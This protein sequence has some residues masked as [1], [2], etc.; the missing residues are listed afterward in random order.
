MKNVYDSAN[1]VVKQVTPDGGVVEFCYD[2]EGMCT[3]ERDQNG[4]M[5]SYESDD[6]FRNIRTIYGDGEEC[7]GYNDSNQMIFYADR[8]GNQTRYSYDTRGNLTGIKDALGN[9]MGFTYDNGGRITSVMSDGKVLGKNGYDGK[10][11][12]VETS[13]ALGRNRKMVYGKNGLPEQIIMPDGS[14]IRLEYDERGNIQS[15]NDPYG[16]ETIYVYDGLNRVTESTDAE[17]NTTSYRYNELNRLISVVNSEGNSRC[18]NYNESGMP[19][20][21]EDFDGSTLSVT[22]NAMGKP[23]RLIDKEGRETVRSYNKSGDISREVSPSGA[24]MDFSYDRNDRLV[25]VELR[26]EDGQQTADMVITYGYDP[27]GNLINVGMGDGSHIFSQTTYS[28]DVLNRMVGKVDS[29][30]GKTVYSYDRLGRISSVTDPSGNQRTFGYNA[31]GELTEETDVRGNTIRYEYNEMGRVTAVTDGAGRTVRNFYVRG[32]RLDKSVYP[33]GSQ[34]D[35]T[36]DKLGRIKSKTDGQGNQ[37]AYEYDRMGRVISV[38]GSEGQNKKYAYDAVGNVISMTD[39]NGNT[40]FYE[41]TLSGMLKTVTDVLGNKTEYIYDSGDRLICVSRKGEAEKESREVFYDRNSFGQVECIRDALG[42]E[43][44][45]AYDA[46]GRVILKTDRDGYQTAYG[47]EADGK[48]KSILYGDGTGVEME[49]TALRQLSLIKDWMG[50]TRV[51][52]DAVG[53]PLNITDY[54]G[55]TVAYEWG[56]MG[57]RKSVNY[58][59]GAKVSYG[60][61]SL[62]RLER[63]EVKGAGRSGIPE[64]ILYRYDTAGRLAEKKLPDGMRTMWRYDGNGQLSELIHEDRNGLLDCYRYEYDLTGNKTAVIKERKG[65]AE[66]SGRYEYGYDALG[67]LTCV[68]KDGYAMRKYAYDCFGN[69]SSM[70]DLAGGKSVSYIYDVLDRLVSS[71]EKGMDGILTEI[72]VRT[73]YFYDRRGNLIREESDGELLRGYE[74]N[75]MNRL[76]KAWNA[77]GQVAHYL[78][79]GLGHRNGKNMEAKQENYLLDFTRPY[80]N[81]LGMER[82]GRRQNFYA[83][84]SITAMEETAGVAGNGGRVAFQGLHCYLQDELGSPLRVS[85]YRAESG[86]SGCRYLTYGYDEFGNDIGK[87][88]ED[89]GIPNLYDGQGIEQPFGYTGYRYDNVGGTYFAQA[90]EYLPGNGRFTAED[91]VK[92][93]RVVPETLNPYSYCR[94]KPHKMVDLDGREEEYVAVIYL[95]NRGTLSGMSDNG[96]LGMGGAFGQGHAAILLVKEDGTGDFFSYAG[97]VEPEA[98]FGNGSEGY[99]SVHLDDNNNMDVVNVD[100]F[101]KDGT[102]ATDRVDSKNKNYPKLDYYS[103]GIYIPIT[104]EEGDAMYEAAME[105]RRNPEKYQLFTHNCNQVAQMILAAGGKDFAPNEFDDIGTRPN[106]VYDRMVEE[107]LEEPCKEELEDWEYGRL[108]ELRLYIYGPTPEGKVGKQIREMVQKL[109]GW[110]MGC[111]K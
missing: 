66:E 62:L 110:K 54:L 6:R 75:A 18:Y 24:V 70:E 67:R 86:I 85:G 22:Y 11:R 107:L 42:G 37:T 81:L 41:Y 21:V 80:H 34:I 47:Y 14:V 69:R 48:V 94:N 8:N 93:N 53:N 60:Y 109:N 87:G 17:G 7:F 65:F 55:R 30:G 61:D 92:G 101:L 29:V 64:E 71:E 79:N 49:Y 27:V 51:E 23:E 38:T 40:A 26:K 82:N 89:A 111:S 15:I 91:V 31:T 95:I 83:D 10:G 68:S 56:S 63:M 58:P 4:Y 36:Y 98:I 102:V 13:D 19:V 43:E 20:S 84:W 105:I 99:L 78:Y 106:T 88:L 2:D 35:Y 45:F 74:Y 59:D 72:P 57:E 16:N 25:K 1:R 104:N 39:V 12:I 5:V 32:G 28:Y 76:A 9:T 77:D 50:E 44:R 100:S 52:R 3:Y 90:R 108:M 46:L 97:A 96:V 33:D 103:H 73:D